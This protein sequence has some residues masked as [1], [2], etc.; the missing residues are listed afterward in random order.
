[1]LFYSHKLIK[2][3]VK[4]RLPW[5]AARPSL[6]MVRRTIFRALRALGAAPSYYPKA[7]LSTI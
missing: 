4:D 6:K 7:T 2:E 3:T 1:M 5:A